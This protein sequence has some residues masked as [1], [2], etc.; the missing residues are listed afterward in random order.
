MVRRVSRWSRPASWQRGRCRCRTAWCFLDTTLEHRGSQTAAGAP[1]AMLIPAETAM[2]LL[3]RELAHVAS[4]RG[5]GPI[6]HFPE[7]IYGS[8]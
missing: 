7:E 4:L 8:P 1:P 2:P 3:M 6:V 5:Q